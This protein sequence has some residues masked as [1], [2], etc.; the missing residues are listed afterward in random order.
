[1]TETTAAALKETPLTPLHRELGARLVPFAGYWMPVQY[2][3]ISEEHRTV[4]EAAGLFDVSHMGEF[5][6]S[7]AGAAAFLDRV[8]VNDVAGL[9]SGRA[10]YSCLC[11]PGGGILDDIVLYALGNAY[12]MVVN[13][14]NA[15]KDLAWLTEHAP[16]GVTVEDR[17]EETALLALQ[18]PRAADVLAPLAGLDV[19]RLR[20]YHFAEGTVTGLPALISRTG[21]TGEDG[22]ELYVGS[23]AAVP[24]WS[25]LLEAGRE[26]GLQ[27]AGLGARDTLRLE[28]KYPLYGND[29]DESTHPLE[30]GLGWIVRLEKGDF[31]GREALAR[32]KAEGLRRKLVGFRLLERAFPRPHHPVWLEGAP[33][34]EEVR[35]GTVSP[36]LG[37]P[38]GTCYL[39]AAAARRGTR[40]EVAIRGRR[41]AAEVV[42]TPFY[43]QGSVKA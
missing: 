22:F 30:A 6:I 4:R 15:E 5:R 41:V 12:L 25:A 21:Y 9:E 2:H 16:P 32:V 26:H 24:L 39:P 13:A 19:R 7:G 43:R 10:Q 29:I 23:E 34:G 8:T 37:W 17:S 14:A 42:P 38:I 28:M 35:S 20:Y 11:R 31:I 40:F 33:T 27:P 1:V 36:T 18:G 3:S